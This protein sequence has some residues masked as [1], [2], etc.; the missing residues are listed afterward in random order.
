MVMVFLHSERTVRKL[1]DWQR[2]EVGGCVPTAV[3]TEEEENSPTA[4]ATRLEAQPQ[5]V[6]EAPWRTTRIQFLLQG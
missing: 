3:G 2:T 5:S 4:W 6:Q 1:F